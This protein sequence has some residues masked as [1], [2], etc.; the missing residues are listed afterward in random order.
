M[1]ENEVDGKRDTLKYGKDLGLEKSK[2]INDL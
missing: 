2:V 1:K